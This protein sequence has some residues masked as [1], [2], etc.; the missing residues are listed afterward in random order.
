MRDI[1]LIRDRHKSKVNLQDFANQ[2]QK[3]EHEIYACKFVL[4]I[5]VRFMVNDSDFKQ[6]YMNI[7]QR[8]LK[9][10]IYGFVR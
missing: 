10:F 4:N 5:N 3:L 1:N 6:P 7:R 9:I 2:L 8:I